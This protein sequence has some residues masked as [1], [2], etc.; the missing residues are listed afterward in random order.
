[1]RDYGL[2][3]ESD[4]LPF[5]THQRIG[6]SGPAGFDPL[7]TG[8]SRPVYAPDS[9]IASVVCAELRLGKDTHRHPECRVV[10]ARTRW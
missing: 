5:T 6:A 10:A 7:P 9:G 1:M 4:Q 2:R 3:A 8:T